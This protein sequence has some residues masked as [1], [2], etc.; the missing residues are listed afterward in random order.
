MKNFVLRQALA[1]EG[2]TLEGFLEHLGHNFL[3]TYPQME[4]LRL[5]ARELP[6]A[7]VT[8]QSKVHRAISWPATSFLDG[9]MHQLL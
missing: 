6:F 2:A 8:Y 7:P 3:G 9:N 4:H 1:F 5:T